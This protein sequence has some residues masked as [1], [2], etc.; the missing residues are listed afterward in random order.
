M[1]NDTVH[2]DLY[3]PLVYVVGY[4]L[5]SELTAGVKSVLRF[6]IGAN[7]VLVYFRICMHSVVGRYIRNRNG[8]NLID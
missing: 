7:F 6:P 5:V 3:F 2:F 4:I 8:H 1:K